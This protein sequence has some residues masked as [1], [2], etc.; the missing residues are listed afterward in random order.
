MTRVPVGSQIVSQHHTYRFDDFLVDPETWKLSKNDE[1]VH[2][3][4]IVL[5]LLIYLISHRDRLVTREELMDTVWGDTVI[6]ESALSKAV[7]R[8]R[9][10]LE[11]DSAAP[12]YLETVHSQG[13]R[14]IAE[15]EESDLPGNLAPPRKAA[16]RSG[17]LIGG[18]AIIAAGLLAA[19]WLR[20]PLNNAPPIEEIGSLAVLP[21]SNLTG[22]PEQ[23]YFVD[24]LQDIL[25]TELSQIGDLRVTSRQSTRRYR[26]SDLSTA[27]IAGELGVDA[28]VEGSLL[29]KGDSIDVT[30]Q[31]IDGRNDVHLWAEQY[32]REA[33][34][35]FDLISDIANAID[36]TISPSR[37]SSVT[38]G[39]TS[40]MID[41]VEPRAVEAYTLGVTQLDRF[42]RDGIRTAIDQ[43]E[44]AVELEPEFALA[45]GQLAA[46]HAMEGLFGFAPP[47]ASIEKARVAAL[48]AIAAD[49][50]M[51]IGHSGLGFVKLWT[52]DFPGGCASIQ[53]ALR[54]NPSDPYALHGDA[55]CLM[56]DGR[57]DESVAR[58][59]DLMMVGPFSAMNS[60]PLVFHLYVARHFDE[61]VAAAK[62]MQVRT[63]QFSVHWF[64]A[65]VYWQQGRFDEALQEERL[66]LE[67]RGDTVL[68]A[69]L[70][71]GFDAAGPTGAM[72]AMAETLVLRANESYVDPFDISE[73]YARSGMADEALYWLEKAVDH[74]SFPITYMAFRPDFDALRDDPRFRDLVDRVHGPGNPISARP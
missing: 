68:L 43:F 12:R 72:R 53:E 45:W 15:V 59:R 1:E 48:R 50:Q 29:R 69:A 62:D 40:A 61:A 26:A 71:K 3:E 14:F 2:L 37:K 67:R 54:L 47:R 24:G 7:A 52:W 46:A 35:V 51:S 32:S 66:E 16:W 33:S 20:A 6:S 70:E 57:M 39:P 74:G 38:E 60:F 58:T 63:P 41:P 42:T 28:L 17:L 22:D 65:T 18:A 13:Y 55:D 34:H 19:F 4:P 10:A 30:V 23:D 9:K 44:A 64:L 27:E 8:L 36:S 5:K 73:I 25:I 21:L 49:D 31:L 11:D 56:H